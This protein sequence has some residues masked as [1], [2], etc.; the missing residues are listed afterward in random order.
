MEQG[1][2]TGKGELMRIS[3]R[4]DV[5]AGAIKIRA[6]GGEPNGLASDSH[7]WVADQRPVQ[8]AE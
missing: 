6:F 2:N 1:S 3:Y 7:Q 4:F 5:A 8:K